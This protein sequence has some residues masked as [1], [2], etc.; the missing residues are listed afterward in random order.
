MLGNERDAGIVR[1]KVLD[2]VLAECQPIAAA[3]GF[4]GGR[5]REGIDRALHFGAGLWED[6][7]EAE[8]VCD[9][10]SDV[11]ELVAKL[12]IVDV[13]ASIERCTD[14]NCLWVRVA[15]GDCQ[16]ATG[17]LSRGLPV[18]TYLDSISTIILE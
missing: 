10:T 12:G 6:G 7:V 13:L 14:N 5:R 16:T 15:V 3:V 11:F 18:S 4:Y 8:D 17:V 2:V 9:N 1:C